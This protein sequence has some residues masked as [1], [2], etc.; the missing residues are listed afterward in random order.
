MD[1]YFKGIDKIDRTGNGTT[2][3]ALRYELTTGLP[4]HDKFHSIKAQGIKNGLENWLR[5]N[6]NASS[7]DR[8]I[9][10][11]ILEDIIDAFKCKPNE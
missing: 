2:A 6:P 11:S 9:A 1:Y 4:V 7:S 3:D 5:D 8:E 10:R